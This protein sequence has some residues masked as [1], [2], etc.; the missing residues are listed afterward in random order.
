MPVSLAHPDK[1]VLRHIGPRPED[2]KAMLDV[3]GA[4]SLDALVDETI[5]RGIRSG[6]SLDLPDA[7]SEQ[8]LLDLVRQIGLKNRVFRSFIGMGYHGCITPPVILRNVVQNP[9]F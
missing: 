3:V 1:F 5:P 4:P 7:M 8:E 9:G 2:E 6:F